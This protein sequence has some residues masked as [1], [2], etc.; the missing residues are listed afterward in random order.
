MKRELRGMGEIELLVPVMAEEPAPVG[1]AL[2]ERHT[3][4]PGSRLVLIDNGKPNARRLLELIAEG[5]RKRVAI[6]EVVIRTKRSASQMLD[7]AEVQDLAAMS[8]AVITGL[9]DCGACSACSVG[10]ALLMEQA[11]VPATVL[12]SDVF[13]A[14]V[15]AFATSLGFPG[16]HSLVVP[17]PVSSKP[18]DQLVVIAATV[19]DQAAQQLAGLPPGPP[20]PR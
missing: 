18:D 20:A 5:L 3:F 12:I 19:I 11:G 9:G 6:S 17:H 4:G 2:A 14:H 10:D 15:A 8:A 1:A 16:Y 13:A 7:E